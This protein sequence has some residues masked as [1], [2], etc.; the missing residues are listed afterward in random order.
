MSVHNFTQRVTPLTSNI[1][2]KLSI[3]IWNKVWTF[4]LCQ[5][6]LDI[7]TMNVVL[8]LF[9][10]S[11][12]IAVFASIQ[13]ASKPIIASSI[14][15]VKTRNKHVWTSKVMIMRKLITYWNVSCLV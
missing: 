10:M 11:R 5:F 3:L 7:Q 13:A 14:L 12:Q 15:L 9:N 1:R 6:Y 4:K 2:I 8:A